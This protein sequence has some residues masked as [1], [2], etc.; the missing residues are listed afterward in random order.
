[1]ISNDV[2][3]KTV[4]SHPCK[5]PVGTVTY[6]PTGQTDTALTKTSSGANIGTRSPSTL[7]YAEFAVD[8][9]HFGLRSLLE[10]TCRRLDSRL[11]V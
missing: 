6:P 1:M 7:A 8:P 10:P 11:S 4:M 5:D 9:H 3:R 2:K